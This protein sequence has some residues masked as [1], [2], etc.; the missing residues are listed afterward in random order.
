MSHLIQQIRDALATQL[1]GLTTTAANV[2]TKRAQ[3]NR[4][5]TTELPA[6]YIGLPAE[7]ITPDTIGFPPAQERE[8]DIPIVALVKEGDDTESTL[9]TIQAEVEVKLYSS[10]SVNTLSGLV[11]RLNITGADPEIDTGLDVAA[12]QLVMNWNALYFTAG[13]APQTAT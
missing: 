6:L 3:V 11:A 5:K 4:L 12:G 9:T 10:Q 7:R 1:A 8:M 2:Y 13:G